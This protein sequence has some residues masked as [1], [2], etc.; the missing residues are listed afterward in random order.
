MEKNNLYIYLADIKTTDGNALMEKFG[1]TFEPAR[2]DR[3][4][5]CTNAREKTTLIATGVL[6]QAA[7]KRFGVSTA[8]IDYKEHGKPFIKGKEDLFFN[9][10]HS[11]NFIMI[12]VSGQEIGIDIQKPVPYKEA[13]VNKILNYEERT[14][15]ADDLVKHLNRIWAIKEAYTKLTGEGISKEFSEI[16][17]EENDFS[18]NVFDKGEPAAKGKIV[19]NDDLYEACVLAKED[20]EVS[21][22]DKLSL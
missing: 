20:F 15:H 19:Y 10:S 14:T 8:D 2:L 3:I 7:L 13:L 6:L 9:I 16:T 1:Q 18:L 17:Y 22:L 11:G 21:E 5:R 4:E 12:A